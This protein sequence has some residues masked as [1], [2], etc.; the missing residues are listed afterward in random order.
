MLSSNAP[1]MTAS[2]DAPPAARSAPHGAMRRAAWKVLPPFAVCAAVL[3]VWQFLIPLGI[4]PGVKAAYL[5]TPSGIAASAIELVREGYGGHSLLAHVLASVL[6]TAAGFTLAACLGV[7][8]GIVLGY[9]S[10]A[11]AFLLPIFGFLRPIPALAFIP[12]VVIWF[13]IGEFAKVF[14]IF[15]T[16]FLYVLL[17]SVS[18]VRSVAADYLRLA[19]NYRIS[20]RAT[21]FKVVFPAALPQIFVSLRTAMALSWAVVVASEL[22]AAQVGLGFLIESASQVYAINTV[23][24]GVALIGLIGVAIDMLFLAVE[25]RLLH[26]VGR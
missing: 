20:T 3:L 8:L 5:G 7:P 14:V 11:G 16:A 9:N 21:L 6:R 25:H 2:A 12:V 1:E 10:R 22:I 15:M 18:G 24:V 4:V 26:W 23:Y 13:G 19:S 17:G